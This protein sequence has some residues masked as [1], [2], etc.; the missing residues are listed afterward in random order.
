MEKLAALSRLA[1]NEEEKK[2]LWKDID[3]I[4][5]YVS[6]IQKVSSTPDIGKRVGMLKNVMREDGDPHPGGLFTKEILAEAPRREGNY[7]SVKKIL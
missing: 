2:D 1:L 3:G 5:N 7:I 4:L 6:E